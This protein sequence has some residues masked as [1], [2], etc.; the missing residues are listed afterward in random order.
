MEAY[1]SRKA[2]A[3][4]DAFALAAMPAIAIHVRRACE[5]PQNGEA[6]AALM[7]AAA[8]AGMAFSNASVALVHGMS[9]PIGAHFH[10]AHGLSN[11]ML[12]PEITNFSISAAPARYA[13]CA[14]VMGWAAA[15]DS[16]D[17]ACG[18]LV[19]NL[20]LLNADLKVPSPSALGHSASSDTLALMADQALAS[21]SPQNNPKVPTQDEIVQLYNRIW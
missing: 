6:R 13:D 7:L 1:V 2:F 8:Q 3:Y 12:L 4:T 20:R 11:A 15:T 16:D 9:R 21:G 18:R 17:L 5:D 14:R 10:V 19:E